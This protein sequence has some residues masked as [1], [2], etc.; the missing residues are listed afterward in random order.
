MNLTDSILKVPELR[1]QSS[2][3]ATKREPKTEQQGAVGYRKSQQTLI[4]PGHKEF[5]PCCQKIK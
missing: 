2:L 1:E 3:A 5:H 4:E